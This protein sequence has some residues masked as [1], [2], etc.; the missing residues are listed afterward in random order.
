M[1]GALLVGE[2]SFLSQCTVWRNRLGS[3]MYCTFP[4]LIT[5][6]EGLDNNLPKISSWVERAHE[7]YQSIN[8]I[9]GLSVESPHS[10]AF[11][12]KIHGKNL[13]QQL[14]LLQTQYQMV[15]IRPFVAIDNQHHGYFTELQVGQNHQSISTAEIV[16][17][18]QKLVNHANA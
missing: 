11:Q 13:N 9:D 7:I 14:E 15:V 4:A 17:F 8:D 18:M 5:G 1:S 16:D 10:N 12:I 6:L 2:E 3:N